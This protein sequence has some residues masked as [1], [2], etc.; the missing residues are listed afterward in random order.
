VKVYI[1]SRSRPE[2][3]DQLLKQ[4][5]PEMQ[6]NAT[7]IVPEGQYERYAPK[8]LTARVE[9]VP[10]EWRIAQIRYL[11]GT[12]AQDDGHEHFMMVD[13]DVEFLVRKNMHDFRLTKAD[14][15]QV[16]GMINVIDQLFLRFPKVSHIGVS[17]REGNN[18]VGNG[19]PWDLVE[20]TTRTMRVVAW[21]T[22]EFMALRHGRVEVM[23]DFDLSLQS[24][25]RG[26]E[27]RVLYYWANGQTATHAP[28]GCA[29]WRTREIHDAS[30]SRLAEL[31]PLT[32][33]TRLKQ[34]MT[35]PMPERLEV[36]VQ[37]KRA[38]EI[39]ASRNG[40]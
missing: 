17:G 10:N 34:N 30:A 20:S 18:R 3:I 2:K 6:H 33:R 39:G 16:A 1:P 26:R 37:W 28:G 7:V 4:L 25:E 12:R 8:T 38:A 40:S 15:G 32:V 23:E 36:T 24:L 19:G 22:K 31:H 9:T 13:D 29:D 21:D 5:P 27:N 14:P 11:I 35:G